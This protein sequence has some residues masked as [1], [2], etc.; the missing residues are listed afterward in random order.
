MKR[1][2][3]T[4]AFCLMLGTSFTAITSCNNDDGIE[5]VVKNKKNK[6]TYSPPAWIQGSWVDEEELD[7]ARGYKFTESGVYF[8]SKDGEVALG[9]SEIDENWKKAEHSSNNKYK[10]ALLDELYIYEVK[11]IDDNH[12]ELKLPVLVSDKPIKFEYYYLKLK[13]RN[14]DFIIPKIFE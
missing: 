6:Y 9:G 12:V 10:F 8:V 1:K 14:K 5:E 2:L 11:Y 3:K 13:R 7:E 4:L